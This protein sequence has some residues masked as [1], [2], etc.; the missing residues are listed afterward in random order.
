MW[1]IEGVPQCSFFLEEG[2]GRKDGGRKKGERTEKKGEE[3]QGGRG[4]L[5]SQYN[6]WE[7]KD[8][9]SRYDLETPYKVTSKTGIRRIKTVSA[10]R[11]TY[12]R[13][14]Q[15]KRTICNA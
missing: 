13:R 8:N 6:I 10:N 1:Y 7:R 9:H 3:S 11:K 2:K 14:E 5:S 12:R 4:D 15:E